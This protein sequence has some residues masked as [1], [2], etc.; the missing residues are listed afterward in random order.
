MSDFKI[1]FT[2]NAKVIKRALADAQKHGLFSLLKY[3]VMLCAT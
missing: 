2:N 1:E 3:C